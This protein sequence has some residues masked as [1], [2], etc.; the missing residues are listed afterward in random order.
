MSTYAIGDLHGCFAP[1]M[2]LLEKIQFN[3]KQDTLWFTGDL[4]NRGPQSLETLRFIQNLG[5]HAITVL[6]NHDLT[7]LAIAF[8]A[9][10]YDSKRH[11]FDDILAARDKDALIH[12]LRH[13][14]FIHEDPDLGY[15]LVHA[16]LPPQWDLALAKS[17][18]K[19]VEIILQS[20]NPRPFF[21][22]FFGNMPN[23]WDPTLTDIDRLR[24]II[25]GF[26]RLRFCNL[27]G[28]LELKT[29][30]SAENG[31]AGYLPWFSIPT[32]KSRD[33]KILFGHWSSLEGQCPEPNVFALDTGCVWGNCLTAMR[34]L[35]GKRFT[36]FL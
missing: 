12:W 22:N 10:P 7:L 27:A 16:G 3:E 4:V 18:A 9:I 23:H 30:A 21:K 1:L 31:P 35:D 6:G 13:R 8:K 28:E 5:S 19:E 29:T 11:H 15:T 34:L 20:E 32:R 17:L 2:R 33:L 14:P 25:N 26:T 24:F 36:E